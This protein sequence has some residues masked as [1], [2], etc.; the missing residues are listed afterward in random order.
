MIL[1]HYAVALAAKRA[2]PR[3]SLGTLVFAA[4]LLDELWPVMLLLGL[5]H[6]RIVPGLMAASPFDFV[7]YPITHSL[8][9]AVGWALL[10]AAVSYAVRRDRKA[11]VILGVA[12]LS[13]WLLDVPMHRPDLQLWPGSSIRVGFGLWSSV[14]ATVVI[15]FGLFACGLALYLRGTRAK[16]RVGSWGLWAFAAVLVAI[17]ASGFFS[18][19]PP[20]EQAV[21]WTTLLLWVFIP[22]TAWVDRHRTEVAASEEAAPATRAAPGATA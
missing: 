11:S 19:A 14:P 21:G 4:Q 1:G 13:H 10:V 6:V 15:E 12:V 20:S 17:F 8:L 7:D 2:E 9:A 22:W 18:P 5:E 3:T 16:D